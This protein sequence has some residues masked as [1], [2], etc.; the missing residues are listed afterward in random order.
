[1]ELEILKLIYD[2][3]A[4]G[5]LVDTKFIDKIIEI[6]VSKKSLNNYVRSVQFTN[7]L[8]KNDYGVACAAYDLLSMKILVDYESIQIAM[9]NR[10]Y[11]DQLFHTLEQVMFRNLTITQYILHE[12]EHAFQNKQADDKSDDSIEAKLVNASFVL[13]QAMKNPRFLSALLKGKIPTQDFI[14]YMVQNKELYKQYYHLNPV[15]RLAQVNSFRTIIN[16]IEPIKEY[17]PNLYEFKQASL[18]E[19]MLRG[20]QDSWD[21]GSCPTQVYLFG[22]GQSN[23]WNELDFYS[24]D[25]S[26][27]MKNVCDKY[28]LARRLSLGLPV[29]YD[30]YNRMN[31]WLQRTNKFNI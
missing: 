23:V 30:E 18:I 27:L 13:E 11:Y 21:Q 31:K 7:K 1:M 19:E 29:S 28:N 4:N 26:Q 3:S 10:S 20:Y 5:K 9:E 16:S 8:D 17:I 15:E 2:Y 14:A 25:S 12:L 24:Q 6:V 22:T